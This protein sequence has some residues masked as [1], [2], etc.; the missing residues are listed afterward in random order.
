M[1]RTCLEHTAGD[2]NPQDESIAPWI[3]LLV[4]AYLAKA[5]LP[6]AYLAH[7]SRARKPQA[8]A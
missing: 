6:E 4:K 5:L 2:A 8:R 1:R 7:K 3:P